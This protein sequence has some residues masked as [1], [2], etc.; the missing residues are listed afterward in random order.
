MRKLCLSVLTL[1]FTGVSFAQEDYY[2]S[3]FEPSDSIEFS[4][5]E[6]IINSQ[7]LLYSRDYTDNHYRSIWRRNTFFNI[8]TNST[9][10]SS[11]NLPTASGTTNLTDEYTNEFG[12]GLQWG[13]T[14]NFH[15]K[16]IGGVVFFGLDY[17][18]MDLNVNRYLAKA[19]PSGYESGK[20]PVPMPW[21]NNKW[22][23]DYGMSLGPSLTLY[24]FTPLHKKALDN[25]RLQVYYHIGY[26]ASMAFIDDVLNPNDDDDDTGLEMAWGHGM[27]T[28]FGVNLTWK[29]I[30]FGYE[31][32]TGSDYKYEYLGKD[33]KYQ[34]TG[35]YR[36]EPKETI[37]TNFK[38]TTNR[39]YIQFR[40]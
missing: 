9:T 16:P 3:E 32:R 33:F 36:D 34:T 28:S 2:S 7:S 31:A 14:Y 8:S 11:D 10:F 5:L 25:I 1:F 38:Q 27:F 21:H 13:H 17:S 19:A 6:S 37:S 20:N 15:R 24:P 30:G 39:V 4:S 12:V 29:F 26:S 40:F 18:W 23:A 35:S 22:T